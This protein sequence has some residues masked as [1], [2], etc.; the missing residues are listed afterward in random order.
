MLHIKISTNFPDWPLLRQTAGSRGVWGNCQ[1]SINSGTDECD[2]WIV[3]EDLLEP[4]SVRCP[5]DNLLL[6]TA[7]P[8]E[9]RTYDQAFIDQFATVITCNPGLTHRN[10]LLRQQSHPWHIGVARDKDNA[11]NHNF[12]SLSH[13]ERPVKNRLLSVICSDKRTTPDHRRRI[14]FVQQLKAVFGDAVDVFGRGFTPIDDKWEAIAP[15]RFHVVLENATHPHWLTEKLADCFLGGAYPFYYGCTNVFEY[16]PQHS[17]T[18]IDIGSPAAA[19]S[20]IQAV[21]SRGLDT[22]ALQAIDSA[23]HFVLT[24]YN[25]FAMLA[26]YFTVREI[27]QTK[28]LCRIQPHDQC[29]PAL[30]PRR[31]KPVWSKLARLWSWTP[32]KLDVKS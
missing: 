10:R 30:H 20:T 29:R 25:L 3:F 7:E 4:G 11:V 8:P 21:M 5:E 23:K 15:Y 12:D 27:A 13:G 16:F 6:I 31:R 19:I 1:F 22:R 17:L 9:I 18:P 28:Q 2:G 24:K 14:E 26:D 32:R